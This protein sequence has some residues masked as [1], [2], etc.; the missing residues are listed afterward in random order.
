MNEAAGWPER[1]DAPTGRPERE[2]AWAESDSAPTRR[3]QR[4]RG[5]ARHR[6]SPPTGKIAGLTN[7]SSATEAGD[8]RPDY[9]KTPAASLCSLERVVRQRGPGKW[10]ADEVEHDG[11]CQSGKAVKEYE[12]PVEG[13]EA[14]SFRRQHER[15]KQTAQAQQAENARQ[16]HQKAPATRQGERDHDKRRNRNICDDENGREHITRCVAA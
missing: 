10:P 8:A 13:E 12:K 5:P 4:E 15:R 14:R 16:S 1:S 2:L 3:W 7:S 6:N 9:G 11:E